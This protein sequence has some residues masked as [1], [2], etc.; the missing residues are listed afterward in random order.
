MQEGKV[1]VDRRPQT[2]M[3]DRR[4]SIADRQ[5]SRLTTSLLRSAS[6]VLVCS[7]P[8]RLGLRSR[9]ISSGLDVCR[10]GLDVSS[11]CSLIM[12]GSCRLLALAASLAISTS[13][14]LRGTT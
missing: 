6:I 13:L 9:L 8:S 11:L 2:K 3:D 4:V 12:L 5:T 1:R 10:H 14:N 7:L